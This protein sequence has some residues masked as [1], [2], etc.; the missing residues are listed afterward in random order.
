MEIVLFFLGVIGLAHIIVDSVIAAPIREWFKEPYCPWFFKWQEGW[1]ELFH[2]PLGFVRKRLF[3]PIGHM[4]GCYQCSGFWCGL[5][6]GWAVF[7]EATFWH[8]LAAGFSGSFIANGAAIFFNYLEAQTI[9][10]LPPENPSDK[11]KE[12]SE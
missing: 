10:N 5:F 3:T 6:L 4:T 12:W 1:K 11:Q 8:V 7:S 9:V 2:D